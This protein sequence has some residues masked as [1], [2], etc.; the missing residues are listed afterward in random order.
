MRLAP[1][2]ATKTEAWAVLRRMLAGVTPEAPDVLVRAVG[3]AF[4]ADRK[5]R[6]ETGRLTRH[7]YDCYVSHWRHLG[8]RFG[9]LDAATLSPATVEDWL[10]GQPWSPSYARAVGSTLLWSYRHAVRAGMLTTNPLAGLKRPRAGRREF[11]ATPELRARLL[12]ACEGRWKDFV[13]CLI[14]TGAR[15]I[16]LAR[17]TA[18]DFDAAAGTLQVANKTAKATGRATRPIVLSS[19][20]AEIV[21]RLA[22]EHPTGPLFRNKHGGPWTGYAWTKRFKAARERAGLPAGFT[23]YS[24][25]HAMATDCIEAGLHPQVI[26]ELMGHASPDMVS[27]VYQKINQRRSVL[28]DAVRKVRG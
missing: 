23:L 8:R 13:E 25:R 27:R 10:E 4:L 11:D 12:A 18:A 17:A 5:A 3:E 7:A 21:G 1:A 15:P 14:E 6:F 28:R 2:D 20:A 19:R 22:S 26:A 16:E 9:R 24:L